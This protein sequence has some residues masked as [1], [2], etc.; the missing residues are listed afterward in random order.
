MGSACIATWLRTDNTC[1]VCRRVF[2]PAEQGQFLAYDPSEDE[3]LDLIYETDET[4]ISFLC[5]FFGG[6]LRLSYETSDIAEQMAEE[7]DLVIDLE[8]HTPR[9]MVSVAIYM[10]THI[11]NERRSLEDISIV[12]GIQ[13]DVIRRAYRRIYPSREQLIR[14]HML[15]SL[16][17]DIA[18]GILDDLPAPDVENGFLNHREHGSHLVHFLIPAHP[19]Q[20]DE[21]CYHCGDDFGYPRSARGICQQIAGKIR[22]GSYF[23]G[24]SP[25]PIVAV[26]LYMTS[27]LM[28]LDTPIKRISE[29]VGISEG[30]IRN[31][32]KSLYFWRG[33]V[34]DSDII[35][36]IRMH[37][38]LQD[39]A[40]PDF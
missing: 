33:E 1:P 39:A 36:N 21:L 4:S 12:S 18:Q 20:L 8:S 14:P 35:D 31:A 11:M 13:A 37:R 28:N 22:D 15:E 3:P 6:G 5:G 16:N 29:V 2:F 24:L 27:H 17:G 32:Y 19:K 25:L 34:I 30:T 26:S 7:L 10:A 38:F 9:F 23:A 40:W